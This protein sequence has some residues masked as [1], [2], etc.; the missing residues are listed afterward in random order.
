MRKS[1]LIQRIALL[2]PHLPDLVCRTLVDK[3]FDAIV[4]HLRSGGAIELRGFG[5]FFL[6][7]HGQR[8]VHNPWTGNT[9]L[10]DQF[11]AVRFRPSKLICARINVNWSTTVKIP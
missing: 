2:N 9:F 6:K 10:K 3:F 1:E 4:D 7:Q 5:R 8:T 11:A